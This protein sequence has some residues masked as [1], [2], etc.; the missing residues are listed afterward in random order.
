M[1]PK[2]VLASSEKS[3]HSS[4]EETTPS[5][6]SQPPS[7]ALN[8][9]KPVLQVAVGKSSDQIVKEEVD[10]DFSFDMPSDQ[11]AIVALALGLAITAI[12]LVWVGCRLRTVKKRLRRG[13]ALNSNEADYLI[14]GMYL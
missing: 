8:Q 14:N 1:M 6:N 3:S 10:S 2:Q 7:V 9:S 13:R 12:M 5:V 4:E 11:G